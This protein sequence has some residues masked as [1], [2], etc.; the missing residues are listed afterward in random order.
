MGK[1][2]RHVYI[3]GQI[4]CLICGI[5]LLGRGLDLKFETAFGIFLIAFHLGRPWRDVFPLDHDKH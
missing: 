2:E 3:I 5:I 4:V 1:I